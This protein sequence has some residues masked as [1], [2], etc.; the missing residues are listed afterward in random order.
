[1]EAA[2]Y[3]T[4]MQTYLS[5]CG[6]ALTIDCLSPSSSLSSDSC[7]EDKWEDHQNCSLMHYVPQLCAVIDMLTLVSSSYRWL[8]A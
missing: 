7:L 1:M 3:S 8:L 5:V 2:L 6:F 4:C